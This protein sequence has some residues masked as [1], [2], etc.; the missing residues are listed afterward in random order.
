M[1]QS[2]FHINPECIL[3]RN[4]TELPRALQVLWDVEGQKSIRPFG[5]IPLKTRMNWFGC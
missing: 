5:R 4:E 3:A 1:D 2:L